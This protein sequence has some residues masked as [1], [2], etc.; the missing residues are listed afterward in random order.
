MT[1]TDLANTIKS[2]LDKFYDKYAKQIANF[3]D[4]HAKKDANFKESV[5]TIIPNQDAKVDNKFSYIPFHSI[6]NIFHTKRVNKT[7]KY[8]QSN[9]LMMTALKKLT[10]A[11]KSA[12]SLK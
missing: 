7:I 3:Y 11:T 6:S 8:L 10:T 2:L 5:R 12:P 1:Q 9:N 4:K